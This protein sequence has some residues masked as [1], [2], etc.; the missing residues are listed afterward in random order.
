MRPGGKDGKLYRISFGTALVGAGSNSVTTAGFYRIASKAASGSGIPQPGGAMTAAGALPLAVGSIYWA[1]AGQSL[2]AGDTVI[3]LTLKLIS[4]VSD[5]QD[6]SQRQSHDV[7]TQA[8][9]DSGSRSYIPG[10]FQE[11]TGTINGVVDVDSEEQYELWGEYREIVYSDGTNA[12]RFPARSV[13][14][15]YMMS[16]RETA[17]AGETEVWEYMPL[18]S[19]SI[20][21]PKPMDGV[22]SFSF[23][24]RIDGKRKPQMIRREVA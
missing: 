13:E 12:G 5:V 7:T 9:T 18:L 15:E 23:N 1:E 10:A 16:R 14:H 4:F 3:P 8:D 11:R 22:Q 24:Y 2:A 17:C 19:E 21:A 20:Q 6:S